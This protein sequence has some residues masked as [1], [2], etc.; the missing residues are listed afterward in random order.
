ML[1]LQILEE[2]FYSLVAVSAEVI[3]HLTEVCELSSVFLPSISPQSGGG[4]KSVSKNSSIFFGGKILGAKKD[5]VVV[6]SCM[7]VSCE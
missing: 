1:L 4:N 6:A 7:V 5:V 2:G 3:Y